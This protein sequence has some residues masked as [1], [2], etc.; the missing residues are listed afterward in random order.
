MQNE[1]VDRIAE[2]GPTAW[3]VFCVMVRDAGQNSVWP[4]TDAIARRVGS[5]SRTV[6]RA[7][8]TLLVAR[9]I[10]RTWRS[11]DRSREYAITPPKE[12]DTSVRSDRSGHQCPQTAASDR[13]P[14]SDPADTSVRK[15]PSVSIPK[16]LRKT[17]TKT[18]TPL[19]PFPEALDTEE[20]Q[21]AVQEW[22]DHHRAIG[23]PYKR[24]AVQFAKL[25]KQFP[26]SAEF[27]AAVDHS[28]ANN[29]QGLFAPGG[30][31]GNRKTT[32][33]RSSRY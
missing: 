17:K 20:V 21:R 13:T 5:T 23:K 22:L 28:I 32:D 1:M 10:H 6:R 24:P 7:I 19:P 26:T 33:R 29:Y 16:R 12:P 25:F 8:E 18:R 27:I 11:T 31:R 14:V 30:K 4:S 2:V 3:A 9:W 15:R